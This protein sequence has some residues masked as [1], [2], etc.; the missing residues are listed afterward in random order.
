[1]TG[2]NNKK[3]NLKSGKKPSKRYVYFEYLLSIFF[4]KYKNNANM[5]I[6]STVGH[7]NSGKI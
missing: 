2:I 6:P 1:M 7:E 4:S 3:P 5:N